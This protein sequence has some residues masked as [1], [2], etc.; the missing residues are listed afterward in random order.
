MPLTVQDNIS[1]QDD[2]ILWQK[3]AFSPAVLSLYYARQHFPLHSP[4]PI[5]KV[6]QFGNV[7]VELTHGNHEKRSSQTH[8][9]VNKN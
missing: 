2:T 9:L 1:P 7:Y 4:V 8:A 3:A 6:V 5:S